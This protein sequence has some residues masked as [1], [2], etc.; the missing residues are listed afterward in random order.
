MKENVTITAEQLREG[1]H[2]D[3]DKPFDDATAAV[4]AGRAVLLVV[5]KAARD[6]D[7]GLRSRGHATPHCTPIGVFIREI[8]GKM[9]RTGKAAA[10][11]R[12][13]AEIP[14]RADVGEESV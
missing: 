14:R 11:R 6:I 1:V 5:Q 8:L 12:R 13:H 7:S 9:V 4:N 3:M 10:C 2:S